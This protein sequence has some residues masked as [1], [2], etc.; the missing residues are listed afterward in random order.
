VFHLSN[1]RF[2]A[3]HF[4][5]GEA[6]QGWNPEAAAAGLTVIKAMVPPRAN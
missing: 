2:V 1:D 4:T 3:A 6:N 5:G